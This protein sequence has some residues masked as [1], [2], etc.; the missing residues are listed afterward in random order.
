MFW[1]VEWR[2]RIFLSFEIEVTKSVMAVW[3]YQNLQLPFASLTLKL[4]RFNYSSLGS[5]SYDLTGFLAILINGPD[6]HSVRDSSPF[7]LFKVPLILLCQIISVE[8]PT[9]FECMLV[10]CHL[11]LIWSLK[12]EIVLRIDLQ[13]ALFLYGDPAPSIGVHIKLNKMQTRTN[14]GHKPQWKK[15]HQF[16]IFWAFYWNYSAKKN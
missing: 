3:V 8:C 14:L 9:N 11:K 15:W 2:G 12:F 4:H 16:K 1:I 7:A 10:S 6:D 13:K 5:R